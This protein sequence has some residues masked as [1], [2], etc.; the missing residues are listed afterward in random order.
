M[1]T[2]HYLDAK[3]RFIQ[4]RNGQHRYEGILCRLE[5]KSRAN[6]KACGRLKCMLCRPE[7]K[8]Q[9]SIEF[10]D[11]HSYTFLNGYRTL[12]NCSAVCY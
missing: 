11:E 1:K 4:M 5:P 3:P 12:L 2:C 8:Q 9:C 6:L 10:A 7:S